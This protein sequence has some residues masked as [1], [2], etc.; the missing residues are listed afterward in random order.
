[1]GDSR[2]ASTTGMSVSEPEFCP[3]DSRPAGTSTITLRSRKSIPWRR[4]PWVCPRLSGF[5]APGGPAVLGNRLFT[6]LGNK[7]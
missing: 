3:P 2:V 6:S 7:V 4:R 1:V 5:V